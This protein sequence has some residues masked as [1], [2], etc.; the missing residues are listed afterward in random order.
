MKNNRIIKL[1]FKC[2]RRN[3]IVVIIYLSIPLIMCCEDFVEIN[4]PVTSLTGNTIFTGD[5]TAISAVTG[6]Y[7]KMIGSSST[8]VSGDQSISWLMGLASDELINYS[9]NV[10]QIEFFDN[11]LLPNN[12]F[13]EV[14]WREFYSIIYAANSILEG[15]E[16]SME[17]TETVKKQLKG[18]T[19]FIRAFCYFYLV[20][21]Y[22]DVPLVTGTDYGV[23]R[24]VSKTPVTEVYDLII[25]DLIIAQDLLNE[26]YGGTQRIRPNKFTATALLARVYLYNEDWANAE[27][28]ASSVIIESELYHLE[29]D[30]NNVFLIESGEA[31]WQLQAITDFF[32]TFDGLRFI[33]TSSPNRAS[34]NHDLVN[35]FEADDDRSIS[36]IGSVTTDTEI[37]YYP[38]KYKIRSSPNPPVEYLTVFRLA[39]Q[40]LIRAEAQARQNKLTGA[41]SDLNTIRVRAGLGNTTATTQTELLNAILLERRMELFTEWGH[42]W[43]DLKRTGR[44]DAIIGNIKPSWQSTDELLPLPEAELNR[45]PNLRPQNSGY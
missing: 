2:F 35:T 33:L 19:M 28:E 34:L 22:G 21:L 40:Y 9:T 7:T 26:D 25:N 10:N 44:L 42:R 5:E 6:I 8:F 45:N 39:E 43:F 38:F 41:A 24:L 32:N 13:V 27:A 17:V 16:T 20:N 3:A 30:L 11:E 31:I 29:S 36:W 37:F 15:L 14:R 12:L 23:N 4:P 1:L 18:E